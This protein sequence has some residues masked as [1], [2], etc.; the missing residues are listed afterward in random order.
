MS[1]HPHGSFVVLDG[2]VIFVGPEPPADRRQ[3]VISDALYWSWPHDPGSVRSW[4][5]RDGRVLIGI[6]QAKLQP[7]DEDYDPD[8]PAEWWKG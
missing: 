8:D 5:I 6:C 3:D 4:D 2:R 1:E 7:E